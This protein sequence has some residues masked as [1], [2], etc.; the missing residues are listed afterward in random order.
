MRQNQI[1][2]EEEVLHKRRTNLVTFRI[3]M[4]VFYFV[5]CVLNTIVVN[6]PVIPHLLL[7]NV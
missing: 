3:N 2:I 1:Q 4:N 6:Y 5:H 7:K